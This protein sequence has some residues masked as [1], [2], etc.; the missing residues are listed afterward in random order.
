MKL[1]SVILLAVGAL[2]SQG[3]NAQEAP[4]PPAP[5]PAAPP[6]SPAPATANVSAPQLGSP[7]TPL[8]PQSIFSILPQFDPG[9]EMVSWNG[10]SWNVLNNRLFEARFE[11][12]LNAP[13]VP[14]EEDQAYQTILDQI[15]TLL[16]PGSATSASV[17]QAFALLPRASDFDIDGRLC[18]AV[19]S[20]VYN[21]WLARREDQRI[22]KAIQTLEEERR[23]HEWNL[24]VTGGKSNLEQA[25]ASTN[26]GRSRQRSTQ[27]TSTDGESTTDSSDTTLTTVPGV[28]GQSISQESVRRLPHVTRIAEVN[29]A[30]LKARARQELPILDA[31][32]RYQSLMVHLF[33]QRRFDHV[34][35]ASQF[36]KHIFGTGEEKLELRGEAERLFT[37]STGLPPTVSV[38]ESLAYELIGDADE[39]VEAFEFLLSEGELASASKRLSEAFMIGEY[40]APLRRLPRE[41]KRRVLDFMRKS[42]QLISAISV[43]D[44]TLADELI[45]KLEEMAADFDS[46]KP[47]AAVETAR[48]LATMH[49]AKAKN[50]AVSG[51]HE[52]LETELVA[53][54]E[55]WPRNPALQEVA[56]LLFRQGD[57]QQRALVDLDQLLSQKNYRQIFDDRSRYIAAVSL[58]PDRQEALEAALTKVQKADTV[59]A[60]A[61]EI[62]KRGDAAGAWESIERVYREVPDDSRLNETR[63]NLTTEAADFVRALRTAEEMEQRDQTGSSLAWYLEALDLYPNSDYAREGIDRIVGTIFPVANAPV[64]REESTETAAPTR[65][66]AS[67][68]P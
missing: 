22:S 54:T 52:T 16:A 21:V 1:L 39:G 55:I 32:I 11:K 40:L 56:S 53:A 37:G 66:A 19:S 33:F 49:L 45:T 6:T 46:S 38:L 2:V 13:P 34:I 43:K 64:S 10:N 17:D 24:Q 7:Q 61:Q 27:Q 9:T 65:A 48:T 5:A 50:A 60:Q 31:R 4:S 44:Y 51:N 42:N 20:A 18:D 14:V 57:V 58:F 26:R 59:I 12:Y 29:A 8:D 63:A 41:E 35:I 3:A 67:L 36:Y 30:L 23:R 25:G 47:K 28:D 68:G 62:A 15:E